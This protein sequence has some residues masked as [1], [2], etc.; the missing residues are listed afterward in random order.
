MRW[1]WQREARVTP[2]ESAQWWVDPAVNQTPGS[3]HLALG[4]RPVGAPGSSVGVPCV[5]ATWQGSA[6]CG[7]ERAVA[8]WG[9]FG[10]PFPFVVSP[11]LPR[12][13]APAH[14]PFSSVPAAHDLRSL[15][16]SGKC[17]C[18]CSGQV[19]LNCG[20]GQPPLGAR[21]RVRKALVTEP[22]AASPGWAVDRRL[23]PLLCLVRE[24]GARQRRARLLRDARSRGEGECRRGHWWV[25]RCHQ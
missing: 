16:D 1:R 8:T 4:G 17:I 15:S 19:A 13:A 2:R 21:G 9:W 24:A 23:S 14:V 5:P 11:F 18:A 20:R 3:R 22:G 7:E 10:A 6:A 12:L 25:R